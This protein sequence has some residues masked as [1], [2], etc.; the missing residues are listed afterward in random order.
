MF[1]KF[2][3]IHICS[4]RGLINERPQYE[5]SSK[6]TKAS[7]SSVS[8][9]CWPLSEQSIQPLGPYQNRLLL[10]WEL[11]WS[12]D[13]DFFFVEKVKL[14]VLSIILAGGGWSCS[15]N[16]G[17]FGVIFKL[18]EFETGA[19]PNVAVLSSTDKD[20]EVVQAKET[21]DLAFTNSSSS[22]EANR[23]WRLPLRIFC[24]NQE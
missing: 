7:Y 11:N 14:T 4:L 15:S 3:G 5:L 21:S 2:P 23:L 19:I 9:P 8:V 22:F 24:N 20:C 13:W 17:W 6:S 18:F 12:K 1:R 10:T 16:K